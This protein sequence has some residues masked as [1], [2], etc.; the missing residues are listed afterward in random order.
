MSKFKK[1]PTHKGFLKPFY[2]NLSAYYY[3]PNMQNSFC[4]LKQWD[5]EL[6]MFH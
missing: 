6:K 1:T 2:N 5:L 3:K 4:N